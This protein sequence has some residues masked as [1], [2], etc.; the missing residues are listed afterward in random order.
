[1]FSEFFI[2]RPIFATVISLIIVL[3][4][5]VSIKVLPVEQYPNIVPPEIQI[6]A[7][8]PG[9][10]AEV[11]ADTVAAPIEQE[12]NGVN[13]MIYMYS[14]ATSSGYLTIGVV[15]EIGTDPDQATIDVNNKV[16]IA[17]AK[18]PSEVTKQGVTVEQKSNS[19]LQVVTMQS[20]NKQYD[21]VYVSNYA[22]LNVLDE[23]KRIPGVGSASLF[24]SQDYSMRIW[25]SPDKLSDYNMT[26]LDVTT[27][28]QEQ[29]SQFAAG[30]FGQ[31]PIGEYLPYTYSVN[32]KGRLV[33]EEEFG[34]IILKSDSSGATLRLKDVARIELGAQDYSVS[35]Q[36][37]NK[38][39]VAFA[40][41]LQ[42]GANALETSNAVKAKMAELAKKF[43]DGITYS[44]PY[45]TTLFVNISIEEVIHTFFEAVVLVILVVYLFLQNWR[46][47]LIPILAVPVSIIGAF[48]GMYVLGFSINLLTLFG[49][50]LAIGIVVDDAIIVLENVERLMT[51]EKLSPKEAAFK[52]M[53]EV[54]GPVVAVALVLSSVFLPIA[55]L[56]GMTGMMYRQFAV[57][58]AISVLIS[59]FVALSLTSALCAL[60]IRKTGGKKE[61][62]AFFRAF[63]RGLKK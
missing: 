31:E 23:I 25:I 34:N 52:A 36:Q 26:P 32:T 30:R 7:T 11:L 61:P 12:L 45:D 2:K 4:G 35:S 55:F 5:L 44:I 37:N 29:N 53:K 20:D 42:S 17:M 62:P 27:A 48:A 3:A 15:F 8:Y 9:A 54:S 49:L 57:T 24:A 1:M 21:T 46:A 13:N 50:I 56:G 58:I 16:Q 28:I 38:S 41:Y 59:A 18:L 14:T 22:L 63:N 33:N 39:A 47:T 60:L 51:E 43:P 40:I 10:T 6:S 19:I